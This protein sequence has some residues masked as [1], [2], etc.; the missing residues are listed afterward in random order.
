MPQRNHDRAP[1]KKNFSIALPKTM[2]DDLQKIADKETRSRNR[3]I[4]HFLSQAV[5]RWK[6]ERKPAV[7]SGSHLSMVADAPG[8][9]SHSTP[10][11]T[12]PITYPKGRQP[13][14]KA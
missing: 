5:E 13:K 3:Q 7:E 6:M 14:K 1:D 8:N 2:I 12:V 4:E 10:A 9:S 11:P